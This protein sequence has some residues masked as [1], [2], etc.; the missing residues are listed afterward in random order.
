[1]INKKKTTGHRNKRDNSECLN[2]DNED[3]FHDIKRQCLPSSSA[4][5]DSTFQSLDQLCGTSTLAVPRSS[6]SSKRP[7]HSVTP[8]CSS[9]CS[10]SPSSSSQH[11]H[12]FSSPNESHASKRLRVASPYSLD[13]SPLHSSPLLPPLPS[14]SLPESPFSQLSDDCDSPFEIPKHSRA[15]R[16]KE[17]YL[18]RISVRP[19]CHYWPT[20]DGKAPK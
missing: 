3:S 8:H 4:S 20:P 5:S 2:V 13:S 15:N 16:L 7:L 6:S 1:M 14:P 12:N 11:H 17:L 18:A 9:S 19:F 10:S